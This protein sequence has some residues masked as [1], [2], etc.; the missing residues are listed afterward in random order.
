MRITSISKKTLGGLLTVSA[1]GLVGC[2][3]DAGSGPSDT[4][5]SDSA[6]LPDNF[7]A[8]S[9]AAPGADASD[10]P[11]V[12]DF[13]PVEGGH[14]CALEITMSLNGQP[15][16]PERRSVA[17]TVRHVAGDGFTTESE[18]RFALAGCVVGWTP[19]EDAS[20]LGEQSCEMAAAAWAEGEVV[21]GVPGGF[22]MTVRRPPT[23]AMPG[24]DT[25]HVFQC[26]PRE[27][28]TL[29]PLE[30]AFN[31]TT[32]NIS[33]GPEQGLPETFET[34]S[35]SP[36]VVEVPE[37]WW[38]EVRSA[39]NAGPPEYEVTPAAPGA[40]TNEPENVLECGFVMESARTISIDWPHAGLT[41]R[42]GVVAG[43]VQTNVSYTAID[44]ARAGGCSDACAFDVDSGTEVVVT[45]QD[46]SADVD[47]SGGSHFCQIV[48]SSRWVCRFTMDSDRTF[49]VTPDR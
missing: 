16:L 8:D 21:P 38:V 42:L 20:I 31:R 39:H 32:V 9:D 4:S 35:N 15:S 7:G 25:T 27:E 19:G 22:E 45:V 14:G 30:V 48:D 46:A 3:D 26:S 23:D 44:E 18:D 36:C 24:F 40:C 43:G 6:A 41:R 33:W 37:G 49:T 10:A 28:A 13:R 29:L 12:G 2:G 34:C 11:S 5:V 1:I 47:V 17:V